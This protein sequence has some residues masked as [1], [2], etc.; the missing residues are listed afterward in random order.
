MP[1]HFPLAIELTLVAA[2][3]YGHE[4]QFQPSRLTFQSIT[5]ILLVQLGGITSLL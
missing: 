1:H 5:E 2:Q 3:E 4:G